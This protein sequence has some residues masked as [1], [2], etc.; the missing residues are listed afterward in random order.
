VHPD[1]SEGFGLPPYLPGH[2]TVPL[3]GSPARP[4]V[5]KEPEGP[6]DGGDEIAEELIEAG[7]QPG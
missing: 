3:G 7:E 5:T 2:P 4:T 1:A 6:A